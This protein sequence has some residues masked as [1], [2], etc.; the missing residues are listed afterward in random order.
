MPDRVARRRGRLVIAAGIAITIAGLGLL[1]WA[2]SS[3]QQYGTDAGGG[4]G[5]L[6]IAIGGF[7]A[8]AA[9][10]D[11]RHEAVRQLRRLPH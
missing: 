8:V 4:L 2:W 1:V 9:G 5:E 11:L 10:T 6:F 3:L 7:A